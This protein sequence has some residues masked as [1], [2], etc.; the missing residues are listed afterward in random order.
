M[1]RIHCLYTGADAQSHFA[2]LPLQLMHD[3]KGRLST[4]LRGAGGWIYSE[5]PE[6]LFTD[7]HTSGA[8]GVTAML[9][10][11]MDLETGG[12]ERRRLAAGDLLFA[13]DTTGQ[14]HRSTVSAGCRGLSLMF[15][16]PLEAVI[17]SLFGRSLAG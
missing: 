9:D 8:G 4:G 17:Q 12:G 15:N 14:G 1:G 11:W 10:G 2:E 7:W 5:S 16:E 6:Q 13:L 3:A